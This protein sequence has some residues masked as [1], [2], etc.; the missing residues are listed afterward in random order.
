MERRVQENKIAGKLEFSEYFRHL[1]QEVGQ[2]I[3]IR[4]GPTP[5]SLVKDK[6]VMNT[7]SIVNIKH[8]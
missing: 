7:L 3:C 2:D 4:F 6:E 1:V 5:T 8:W